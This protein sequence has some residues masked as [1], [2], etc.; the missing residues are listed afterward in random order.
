MKT[1]LARCVVSAALQPILALTS[2]LRS[3]GTLQFLFCSHTSVPSH[4]LSTCTL[5][6]HPIVLR[7]LVVYFLIKNV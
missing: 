2:R 4:R 3:Y 6:L 7:S 1:T 5:H